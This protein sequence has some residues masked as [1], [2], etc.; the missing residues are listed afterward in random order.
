ML[1]MGL[2]AMAAEENGVIEVVVRRGETPVAGCLVEIFRAG[3]A[4]EDGYRLENAFGGGMILME[5]VFSPDLAR[6]MAEGAENGL[7]GQ[8]DREGRTSFGE[9]PY[10]LYLVVD[11]A[12][13]A[14]SP[15]LVS[16]SP[17]FPYIDTYPQ[18]DLPGAVL[19]KTGTPPA[20]DR[21]MLGLPVSLGALLI[22]FS[23]KVRKS[24]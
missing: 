4:M 10:G 7:V 9:L 5:D 2:P 15:F 11:R 14:F 19:P 20:V 22:L 21:A 16:I 6:W 13:E 8:T 17:E 12:G 1:V 24:L 3:E 18:P 23:R